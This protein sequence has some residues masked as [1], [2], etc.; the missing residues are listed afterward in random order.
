MRYKQAR[1]HTPP[2]EEVWV[3]LLRGPTVRLGDDDGDLHRC[4]KLSTLIIMPDDAK[5]LDEAYNQY[6]PIMNAYGM[7]EEKANDRFLRM[8]ASVFFGEAQSEHLH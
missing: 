7:N 5:L 3:E 8:A 2:L 1:H 6:Q 4:G